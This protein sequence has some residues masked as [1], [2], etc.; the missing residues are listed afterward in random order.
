MRNNAVFAEPYSHGEGKRN[1]KRKI[2]P[3]ITS[4]GC[5]AD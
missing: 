2:V 3:P 5:G 1:G 4:A